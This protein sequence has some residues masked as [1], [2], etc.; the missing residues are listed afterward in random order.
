MYAPK[1]LVLL[2]M[3]ISASAISTQHL[4]RNVHHRHHAVA[5]RDAAPEATVVVPSV[6]PRKR[7]ITRCK[8][9]NPTSSLLSS[10]AVPTSSAVPSSSAV[11]SSSVVSAVIPSSS[12]VPDNVVAASSTSE[13]PVSS[14]TPPPPPSSSEVAP[15]SSS[16]PP[17]VTTSSVAPIIVISTSSPAP[18]PSTS[19]EAAP[20]THST[21]PVQ[22]PSSSAAAS[23]PTGSSGSG[24][25]LTSSH[26]GDGTFYAT[27]LGACGI[28]NVDTDHIAAVSHLLFD[29]FPGYTGE[30]PNNNPICNMK[31]TATWGG[32]SVQVTITDRC[33]GCDMFSL[34]FSPSAFDELAAE[35]IGRLT[36]MVWTF[37]L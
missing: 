15:S 1:A 25:L 26:T 28:N 19:K 3:A 10:S 20:T 5:A 13:P 35:S 32:K 27:G 22:T 18:P 29:T 24:D 33:E 11:V 14:S 4:A 6:V 7:A 8:A 31:A 16:V 23:T 34:D 36:G 12:S 21:T 30:N 9:G 17:P 37:D 2:A